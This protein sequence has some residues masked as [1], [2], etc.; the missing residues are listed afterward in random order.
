MCKGW[1]IHMKAKEYLR[2][3]YNLD[4]FIDASLLEL[5]KLREQCNVIKSL[6][7]SKDKVQAPG[8]NTMEDAI[9]KLVDMENDINKKIEQLSDLKAEIRDNIN[10]LP[11]DTERLLLTYR[12]LCFLSWEEIAAKMGYSY[13]NIHRVHAKALRD[14]ETWHTMS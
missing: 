3:A 6:D 8:K 12:Y 2:R 4:K 13:R 11:D 14:F 5:L 7:Y 10:K 9:V 1:V